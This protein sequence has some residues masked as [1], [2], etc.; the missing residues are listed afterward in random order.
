MGN[1][2]KEDWGYPWK[3]GNIWG[4]NEASKGEGKMARN[5]SLKCLR[6]QHQNL[7][8]LTPLGKCHVNRAVSKNPRSL[9]TALCTGGHRRL[10]ANLQQ[11]TANCQQ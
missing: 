3:M 9:W 8:R 1:V 4:C 6:V 7:C 10:T 2:G 11:W 5:G